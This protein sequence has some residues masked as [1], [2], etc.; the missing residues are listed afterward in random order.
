MK[1]HTPEQNRFLN[2]TI[3]EIIDI[4]FK[5][6]SAPFF[7]LNVGNLIINAES[8]NFEVNTTFEKSISNELANSTGDRKN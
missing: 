5:K 4:K 2:E 7:P 6:L 8:G 1:K 3:V